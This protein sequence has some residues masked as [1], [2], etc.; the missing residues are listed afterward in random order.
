VGVGGGGRVALSSVDLAAGLARDGFAVV[1]VSLT[2]GDDLARMRRLLDDL[3]GSFST[4]PARI[5][6][7]LGD[8]KTHAGRQQIPEIIQPSR[9]A[10]ELVDT[11][12]FRSCRALAV[13]LLGERPRRWF[14]H[15]ICKPPGDDT[16][17]GWHQDQAYV[18]GP[19]DRAV[20]FWVPLQDVD[21]R[22]GCMEFMPG[23]HRAGGVAHQRRGHRDES[24][25]LVAEGVDGARGVSCPLRAGMA[26]VHLP[27]TL[28]RTGPNRSSGERLA[29][30]LQFKVGDEFAVPRWD[31]RMRRLAG[32]M[33]HIA[34]RS[35]R[36]RP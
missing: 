28:H 3:F 15:A 5:A 14:D 8:V 20:H 23:S 6:Y 9:L 25:A 22:N 31:Q 1:D 10:P 12:V 29:W 21:E 19:A 4:L 27:A 2:T 7:D 32:S 18:P 17:I 26:T 36:T 16:E 13:E 30:I 11:T 34:R 24:H 35:A 33:K